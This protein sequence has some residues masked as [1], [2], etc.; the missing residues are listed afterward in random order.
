M[1]NKK[2]SQVEDNV[3]L[4]NIRI[5]ADNILEGCRKTAPMIDRTISACSGRWYNTLR[6]EQ[7]N[8]CF[9]LVSE[10]QIKQNGKITR[11]KKKKPTKDNFIKRL[12]K[13]IFKRP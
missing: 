6:K 7:S 10:T 4:H 2:W 5:S 12:L 8:K 13:K 9:A 11:K 1:E 3:L